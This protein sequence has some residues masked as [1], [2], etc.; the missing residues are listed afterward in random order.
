MTAEPIGL[1]STRTTGIERAASCGYGD[2]RLGYPA[3]DRDTMVTLKT[4]PS[5]CTAT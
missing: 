4:R 3:L 2:G 1:A 5:P